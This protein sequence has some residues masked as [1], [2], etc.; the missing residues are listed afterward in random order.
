MGMEKISEAILVKVQAEA[1]DII[2]AAEERARAIIEEAK[3][4]REV[5]FEVEKN[6]LMEGAKA[7]ASRILAQAF[8]KARQELSAAKVKLI[9][10]II[11]GAWKTL[12][13]SALDENSVLH[14]IKEAAGALGVAQARVYVSTKDVEVVEKLIQADQELARRIKEVK[15][16]D[17]AGG[18]VLESMDGKIRIDNTYEAR[19]EMLLP[20]LMPE[21]SKSLFQG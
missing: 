6:R 14:L 1:E 4:Q 16:L 10:D 7:E 19:L 17:C 11:D 20:K 9:D 5:K 18:A 12:T 15:E 13:T 8:I 3:K 21:I 2:K